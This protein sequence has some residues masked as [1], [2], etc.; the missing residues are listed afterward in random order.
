MTPRLLL[1]L[2]LSFVVAIAVGAFL[3]GC[4]FLP[5]RAPCRPE[6]AQALEARC[7]AIA[8]AC[9]PLPAACAPLDA[10]LTEADDRERECLR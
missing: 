8:K 3:G 5:A 1:G 2:A 4:A 6:D 9:A 7:V 10:C